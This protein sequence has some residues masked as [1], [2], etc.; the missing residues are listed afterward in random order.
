M[1][2]PR[3]NQVAF[4]AHPERR[5][6]TRIKIKIEDDVVYHRHQCITDPLDACGANRTAQCFKKTFR[7]I[8]AAL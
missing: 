1:L 2:T 8:S 7:Q 3:N 6:I 5:E 4:D